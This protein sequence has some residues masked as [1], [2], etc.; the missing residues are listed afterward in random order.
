V[1]DDIDFIAA[2]YDAII[3]PSGWDEVVKRIVEETKLIGGVI[4]THQFDALTHQVDAAHVT[5]LCNIDPFYADA[6]V[7]NYYKIN[8]LA[9]TAVAIAPG[10]VLA[11]SS[12]TQTDSF[13]ASAFYNEFLRPQGCAD[14][15]FVGLRRTPT[16]SE[17]LA[18]HRSPNA[19]GVEPMEWNLLESIAPH[20]K[21]AAAIHE[22]L[23][24][25][26]ATT[27]TL[28]TAVAA[29]GFA[30]FLLTGDCRVLF[31]NAKAEDLLR[32]GIGLRYERG[33]LAATSPVLSA[34]L[35]ALARQGACHTTGETHVGGTLELCRG[36]NHPPLIAYVIPLAPIRTATLFDLDRPAAAVFVVN[37][38]AGFGAQIQSFATR[39]GL[40]GAEE[41]VLAEIIAGNGLL[42]AATKLKIT[43]ATARTHARRILAKTGTNRQ[44]ELI[45]R[46]F[47]TSLPSSPGGA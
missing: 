20:L 46:F 18:L 36:E 21:R 47:E 32:R 42:A 33:R 45:R 34:R 9:A 11:A 12:I 29:A 24:R 19:I 27:D 7:Q 3:E 25:A 30:V 39:F 38:A 43:E 26:R 41:R 14:L 4:V 40:T 17:L 1:A 13:R 8:P 6:F 10:E 37:P 22:L 35:R 2:I 44:T 16:T 31:A 5:T 28:A 15:I 23:A